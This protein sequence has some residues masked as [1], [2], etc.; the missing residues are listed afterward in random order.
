MSCFLSVLYK[1]QKITLIQWLDIQKVPKSGTFCGDVSPQPGNT[2]IS[3][4]LSDLKTFIRDTYL[5]NIRV[6]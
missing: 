2:M 5:A 1:I 6:R 3:V 4:S